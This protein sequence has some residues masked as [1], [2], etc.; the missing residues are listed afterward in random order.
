[1]PYAEQQSLSALLHTDPPRNYERQL[2]RQQAKIPVTKVDRLGS[3]EC[4]NDARVV[5]SH[6]PADLLAQRLIPI[7]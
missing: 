6:C 1:V 2:V 7:Q 5:H 3:A 4:A